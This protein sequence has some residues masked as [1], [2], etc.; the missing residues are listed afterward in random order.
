VD[1][2]NLLYKKENHIAILSINRPDQLNAL[3][4]SVLDELDEALEMIRKR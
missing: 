2:N 4:T 1:F 3:N